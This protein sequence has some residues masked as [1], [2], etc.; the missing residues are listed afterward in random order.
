M[1]IPI[2]QKTT[3]SNGVRVISESHPHAHSQTIGVWVEAG[4]VFENKREA[5]VAHMLE[6]MVFKG[7]DAFSATQI[8]NLVDDIG[9]QMNAFTDREFVCFHIKVL[10]DKAA[11]AVKLL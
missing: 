3:L 5:G 11:V 6:H 2:F 7:T 1:T 9:G 10:S 8:A 4:T